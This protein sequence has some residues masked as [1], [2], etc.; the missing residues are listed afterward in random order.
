MGKVFMMDDD[1]TPEVSCQN[2]NA[3]AD[4]QTVQQA[5]KEDK[6]FLSKK[7]IWHGLIIFFVGT[8]LGLL[9]YLASYFSLNAFDIHYLISATLAIVIS[10]FI[11]NA[12]NKAMGAKKSKIQSPI[13]M[14]LFIAFIFTVI[15]GYKSH[16]FP[17]LPSN[18]AKEIG[19]P[20]VKVLNFNGIDT[21]RQLSR[22]P[23]LAGEVY[24]L[25]VQG[26]AVN[27]VD[28][29]NLIELTE[30]HGAYLFRV[31]TAGTPTVK[32]ANNGGTRSIVKIE[33]Q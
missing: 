1:E 15:I 25:T 28:G 12:L 14:V 30:E 31:D 32:G 27:L 20:K 19:I 5:E 13:I 17:S 21:T 16:G 18:Q 11:L 2:S 3:G 6:D 4:D 22:I 24:R 8:G 33:R 7:E 9:V 29:S 26:A 10:I 23:L